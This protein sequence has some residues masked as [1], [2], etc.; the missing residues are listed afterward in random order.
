MAQCA[1]TR[2]P[3]AMTRVPWTSVSSRLAA[4]VLFAA[5]FFIPAPAGAAPILVGASGCTG[6]VADSAV[7]NCALAS[8]DPLGEGPL[9]IQGIFSA[10]EDVALFQFV[11]TA[12][13]FVSASAGYQ[14]GMLDPMLGLFHATGGDIVQYFDPLLGAPTDAEIDDTPDNS[15]DAVL[16]SLELEAGIYILAL[17]H[18]GNTFSASP[19]G[20]ET[21][22]RDNLGAGFGW[23]LDASSRSGRCSIEGL[24]GFS[25]ALSAVPAAPASVPE[26]GTLTLMALGAGAAALARRR[27]TRR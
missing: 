7:Q 16:P 12:S 4:A 18:G 11:L 26:P 15:L 20:T 9:S 14:D 5:L 13:S 21:P 25:V 24:C 17:L 2:A 19:L 10:D 8:V 6:L 1:H 27:R 23:D 22:P 3:N